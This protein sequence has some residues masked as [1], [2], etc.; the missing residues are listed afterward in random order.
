MAEN[1]LDTKIKTKIGGIRFGGETSVRSLVDNRPLTI[2]FIVSTLFRGGAEVST[3]TLCTELTKNGHTVCLLNL[4]HSDNLS[5]RLLELDIIDNVGYYMYYNTNDSGERKEIILKFLQETNPDLII[6]GQVSFIY[7]ALSELR[8]HCPT[9]HWSHSDL[10]VSREL[11]RERKLDGV[12][13]V[14]HEGARLRIV[15]DKIARDKIYTL[16]NGVYADKCS[17][18]QSMRRSL[19]IPED[20]FVVGMVGNMNDLKNP[21]MGLH[22]F[23]KA[24]KTTKA[25]AY[26]IFAGNPHDKSK[27]VADIA[28]QQGITKRVRILGIIDNVKDV[29]ATIDIMLNC[30]SSEGFPMTIIEAMHNGIPVIATAV[31]GNPESVIHGYTGYLFD[32]ANMDACS[33]HIVTMIRN[34][35]QRELFSKNAK[36]DAIGIHTASVMYRNFM[37]ISDR[38]LLRPKDLKISVVMPV[39]NVEKYVADSINSILRQTEDAFEFIIVNDGST[40]STGKI[41]EHYAQ[42]DSR[43]K[44]LHSAHGGIVSALNKGI[45]IAQCPIIARMDGD[46]IAAGDRFE[47]Q[48]AYLKSNPSVHLLGG[49][50]VGFSDNGIGD[51]STLPL[52]HNSITEHF[53][54]NNAVAHPTVMF[55]KHIWE[56]SGGY[57]GDNRAEDYTLWCKLVGMGYIFANMSDVLA[58]HRDSHGHDPNYGKWVNSILPAIKK[59]YKENQYGTRTIV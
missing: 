11:S 16:H 8:Y 25:D 35:E 27:E 45:K 7:D 43:I 10:D 30:S 38:Y 4:T 50:I 2:A 19:D 9:L 52:D 34:K 57:E 51:P 58:Y 39:Y 31:G 53:L 21:Q 49:Q 46:D 56:K 14:S 28:E 32:P 44:I 17:G 1:V 20:A 3:L 6:Y 36:A 48:L 12:I 40:D 42:Q 26:M 13:T 41:A 37:L 5:E 59:L 15:E 29:Y 33:D 22:A 47:K 23:I 55:Y 24:L 18:G 54:N